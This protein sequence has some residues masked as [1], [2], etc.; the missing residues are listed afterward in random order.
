MN[1]NMNE[2]LLIEFFQ[3]LHPQGE[4]RLNGIMLKQREIADIIG[5]SQ[6]T[7]S[8]IENQK[9]DFEPEE[10][11]RLLEFLEAKRHP[12]LQN[13]IE[14]GKKLLLT[15]EQ[16]NQAIPQSIDELEARDLEKAEAL[17][18][19][20]FNQRHLPRVLHGVAEVREA[21]IALAY[22]S[23]EHGGFFKA[24][25]TAA[26]S[27]WQPN[28]TEEAGLSIRRQTDYRER[29]LD[30]PQLM[31]MRL[32]RQLLRRGF[33]RDNLRIEY[34]WRVPSL[35]LLQALSDK[36]KKPKE[37]NGS[38][39][40]LDEAAKNAQLRYALA[41][42]RLKR[43]VR[44]VLG[45]MPS[46][47][48]SRF[49]GYQLP[50][51]KLGELDSTKT[52][53][54]DDGSATTTNQVE[55]SATT[56]NQVEGSATTANQV[57]G[58][59]TTANQV[60]GSAKTA[61]HDEIV[62]TDLENLWW[63]RPAKD[64]YA[65]QLKNG[66]F[67][68]LLMLS[69]EHND[70]IYSGHA[71]KALLV[72][73]DA[74]KLFIEHISAY[75]PIETKGSDNHTIFKVLNGLPEQEKRLLAL[76]QQ[77]FEIAKK[78]KAKLQVTRRMMSYDL[79]SLARAKSEFEIGQLSF[80][81][82]DFPG[83]EKDAFIKLAKERFDDLEEFESYLPTLKEKLEKQFESDLTKLETEQEKQQARKEQEEQKELQCTI[84][85]SLMPKE[86]FYALMDKYGA[87]SGR[88]DV[89]GFRGRIFEDNSKDLVI[90]RL[91]QLKKRLE[92]GYISIRLTKDD[93]TR[94]AFANKLSFSAYCHD[95]TYTTVFEKR[96]LYAKQNSSL[97]Q[98]TYGE[99]E[100]EFAYAA[101][102]LFEEYWI[103]AGIEIANERPEL[104]GV[105]TYKDLEFYAA[106]VAEAAKAEVLEIIDT[107]LASL[108]HEAIKT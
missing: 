99:L 1:M 26:L 34:V 107:T 5:R 10:L 76:D 67:F 68:A 8:E 73:G 20:L 88:Y 46:A 35:S 74:A 61:S 55:G 50:L 83:K 75:T 63:N 102:F 9:R 104:R 23:S 59:A 11:K 92:L 6:K 43:A 96:D 93:L 82:Y 78:S 45:I 13:A 95:K 101:W 72:S 21:A 70:S 90:A 38:A 22:L 28:R 56:T 94:R 25:S 4:R 12:K 30:F 89:F 87:N 3:A 103:R 84:L 108:G 31:E 97:R 32:Y 106:K 49:S 100:E 60:E 48:D 41:L 47:P 66:Q 71:S 39:P 91:I 105:N 62:E 17:A 42:E 86:V 98:N 19:R 44:I 53:N 81:N 29:V 65:A 52:K 24:T 33:E 27:I 40:K 7:V 57:E 15:L 51:F 16:A 37:K 54:Q 58:S 79:F 69:T 64:F 14:I 2:S 77:T 85:E 18:N 36:H 80:Q